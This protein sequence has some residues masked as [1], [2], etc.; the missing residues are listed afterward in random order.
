MMECTV[1]KS[2]DQASLW[3]TITMLVDGRSR[4]YVFFLHLHHHD[5][6]TTHAN[7]TS[8]ARVS[9]F[10]LPDNERGNRLQDREHTKRQVM[11]YC[12]IRTS[13][14]E[15]FSAILSL[16]NKL[17]WFNLNFSFFSASSCFG[18]WTPFPFSPGHELGFSRR[19]CGCQTFSWYVE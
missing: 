18:I 8:L 3:K 16:A 9:A 12:S 4:G 5:C 13:G 6:H 14:S 7:R 17:N 19:T 10:P 15:R 1:L 11:T 2:V